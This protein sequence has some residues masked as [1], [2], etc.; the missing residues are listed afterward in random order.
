MASFDIHKQAGMM[1][2]MMMMMSELSVG[3]RETIR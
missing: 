1:M 2:M 3:S